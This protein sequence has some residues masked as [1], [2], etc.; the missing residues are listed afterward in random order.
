LANKYPDIQTWKVY[1]LNDDVLSGRL[2]FTPAGF[3]GMLSLTNGE[4]VLIDPETVNGTNYYKS[5][6]H[7]SD[8]TAPHQC[9]LKQVSATP[10]QNRSGKRL[11]KAGNTLH[12]YRLAVATTGQYT[13]FFGG[14]VDD[15]MA[16][17]ST[18][19]NRVDE[20]YERDL[21]IRLKLVAENNQIIYTDPVNDPYSNGYDNLMADQNIANL[22]RVIGATNYDIGHVFGIGDGGI[23]GVGVVC[24][25]V[26]KAGASTSISSPTGDKFNIDFVAHEIGHQ[27]GAMHSFNGTKLNCVERQADTAFEPGSGSSIMAYAGICGSDNLQ[28]HTDAFFHASSIE[29]ITN[30]SHNGKGATCAEKKG[31]GNSNPIAKAGTNRTIPAK[32]PFTLLA[33]ATDADGDTLTYTWDQMDAGTASDVDID[34]GDNAI[35]RSYLPTS[36]PERMIPKLSDLL[37]GTHTKGEILPQTSRTLNFRLAVRDGKGGVGFDDIQLAVHDTGSAFSVTSQSSSPTLAKGKKTKVTWKVANTDA[38]P[39]NC[40][41]VDIGLS[42]NWGKSFKTIVSNV[43]NDGSQSITIPANTVSSTKARIKVSCSNNIFFAISPK[44]FSIG[45]KATEGSGSGGG[46]VLPQTLFL[47]SILAGFI[48]LRRSITQA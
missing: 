40:D 13:E 34:K 37:V 38:S 31:L 4:T 44:N 15:A 48:S 29:Q 23:A 10:V 18:T 11:A 5:H 36:S 9:S 2:D 1:G 19:I 32:T 6:Q 22:N 16:A 21:S 27:F 20:I 14:T 25:D 33:S 39:I 42:T 35:I 41:K 7:R 24:N 45:N 46:S 47:L 26:A 8:D 17:V 3:H 43:Q 30:F 12:T 28:R